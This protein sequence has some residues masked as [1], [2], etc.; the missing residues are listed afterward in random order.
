MMDG[1]RGTKYMEM[2]NSYKL[3]MPGPIIS[4]F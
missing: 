1:I 3:K 4:Y 2:A